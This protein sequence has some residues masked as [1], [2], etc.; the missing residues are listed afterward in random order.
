[1]NPR[2]LSVFFRAG[3]GSLLVSTTTVLAQSPLVGMQ[4]RGIAEAGYVLETVVHAPD[5]QFSFVPPSTWKP[6]ADPER[7]RWTWVS[8]DMTAQLVL[9]IRFDASLPAVLPPA[10]TLQRD[11]TNRY[12]GARIVEQFPCHAGNGQGLVFDLEEPVDH[13]LKRAIRVA[14]VPLRGGIAEFTLVTSTT[15]LPRYHHAMNGL[16]NSFRIVPRIASSG[17]AFA[18]GG[19]AAVAQAGTAN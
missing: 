12:A 3:L 14:Q 8:R 15:A 10:E 4:Q 17:N 18:S 16:M 11:L 2:T 5:F 1:M 6:G 19:P 9:S 13:M 7:L